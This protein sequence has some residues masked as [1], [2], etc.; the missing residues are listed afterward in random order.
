MINILN[1]NWNNINNKW[2]GSKSLISL[3]TIA[4]SVPT[5]LIL[6][7]GDTTTNPYDVTN[8]FDNY[9]ASIAETTKKQPIKYIYKFFSDYLLNERSS[10]IFLKPTDKEEI[11]NIVFSLNSN[12]DSGPNSIPYR[13]LFLLK[14]EISKQLA[15]LFKFS[16][17][18]GVFISI[19][20][21]SKV[22][23]VS[24]KGS[25]LDYSNYRPISLYTNT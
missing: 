9:F 14:N 11:A 6:D 7:N 3:K 22:V 12:K 13:I 17:M 10:T 4:S 15:D 20:K 18:T 23:L 24:K 19:L 1:K 21:T 25:K 2:K 5:V 8:T 16:F